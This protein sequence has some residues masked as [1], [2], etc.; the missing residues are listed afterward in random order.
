MQATLEYAMAIAGNADRWVP[1]CQGT[2][3]PFVSRS[4]IRL[5]YCYNPRQQTHAYVNADTDTVMTFE[6]AQ[7]ALM[8]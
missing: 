8:I 5:L 7:A 2:E 1:A 6:E 4:G 3:K